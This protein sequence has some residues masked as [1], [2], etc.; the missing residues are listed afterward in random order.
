MAEFERSLIS[1]RTKA[2]MQAAR[3]KGRWPGRPR[4]LNPA[5]IDQVH[6]M[7]LCD[8]LPLNLIAERMTV[9]KSTVR[10]A[11]AER[12]LEQSGLRDASRLVQ[13]P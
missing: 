11:V 13:R 5:Q 7:A 2:G 6:R 12:S 9:S 8:E 4:R 10:R 1:E 3:K